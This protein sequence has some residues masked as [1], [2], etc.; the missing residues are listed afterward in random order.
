V[1]DDLHGTCDD[2]EFSEKDRN[3]ILSTKKN[4]VLETG[5]SGTVI[6]LFDKSK[7][8]D[9]FKTVV[10]GGHHMYD[11]RSERVM[12]NYKYKEKTLCHDLTK[13][14]LMLIL[15]DLHDVFFIKATL[16]KM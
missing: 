7:C 14:K 3:T 9:I 10:I 11:Q 4:Y 2:D 13:C 15:G 6:S 16:R 8:Q 1:L 5:N 12:I